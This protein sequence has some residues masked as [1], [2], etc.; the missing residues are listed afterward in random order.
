MKADVEEIDEKEG[1]IDRSKTGNGYE[2]QGH[3]KRSIS[4]RCGRLWATQFK[5]MTPS[6]LQ[7]LDL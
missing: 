7:E 1:M 5:T 3:K 6:L 2:E 4:G